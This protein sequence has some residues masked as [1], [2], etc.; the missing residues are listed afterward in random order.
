MPSAFGCQF[1]RAGVKVHV[2][3]VCKML[4]R[5]KKHTFYRILLI[6]YNK[7]KLTWRLIY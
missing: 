6:Q 3:T 4:S 2:N 5:A 1:F 7:I